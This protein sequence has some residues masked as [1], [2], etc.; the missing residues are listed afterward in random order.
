[1]RL[2]PVRVQGVEAPG[3]I[4]AA[5]RYANLHKLA[6]LLIVGRGGGSIEDLWAF[7]DERVAYAIFES[8]IPIIS[9]VGHEPDVTISDFVADLRA[10]TP[11]NA[12][13]LAV[14]DQESLRQTLDSM[15]ESMAYSLQRQL[16]GARQHLKTLAS[17]SSLQSPDAYLRQ[18]RE[19]LS[20]VT[21]RLVAAQSRGISVNKQRFVALTSKLDAMSPLKVLTRGYAMPQ[22][23]DGS[24][25]KSVKSVAV[26]DTIKVALQDGIVSAQVSDIKENA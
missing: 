13:E 9:A 11:S 18:R 14:P 2:L 5:I 8:Q 3:E 7:N 16:K 6:D 19:L 26:G 4:V 12:A 10:A 22:K 21:T 1:M 24:L 15:Q 25:L 20:A 23:G 17:S